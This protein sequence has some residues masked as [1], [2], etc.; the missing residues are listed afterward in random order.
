MQILHL[1]S[2]NHLVQY[3]VNFIGLWVR[4]GFLLPELE[5]PEELLF[6]QTVLEMSVQLFTA[7]SSSL[8]LVV[9]KEMILSS[10]K[11]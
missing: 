6:L 9:K 7:S 8:H 5:L 11:N 3:K 10:P 4:K 2:C 1:I